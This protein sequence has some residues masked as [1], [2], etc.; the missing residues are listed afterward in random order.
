MTMIKTRQ[1]LLDQCTF[2]LA[3][4]A[5]I[6]PLFGIAIASTFLGLAILSFVIELV[7]TRSLEIFLP[8]IKAPLLLFMGTTLAALIFSP[9]PALGWGPVKKFWLFLLIPLIAAKFSRQRLSCAYSSF[10]LAGFVAAV[11]SLTQVGRLAHLAIGARITGFMGHWMT[12]SGE[13]LLVFTAL[14]AYLLFARPSRL[15]LWGIGIAII[16]CALALTMTRS[17]WIA[18][19]LGLLF[20]F[21]LRFFHWKMVLALGLAAGLLA[22]LM[23][24]KIQNRLK[25][26]SDPRDTSNYARLAFWKAGI[27]MVEAH[28]LAGVG[29]QRI[30]KVFYDYDL[31]PEDRNRL[32]F[33]P[34]HLH[35]NMLQLAAERGIPCALAWLWLIFRIGW[36]H[37]RGFRRSNGDDFQKGICAAGFISVA[38]LFVAG[39][40]EFNFGD[41]EVL[42]LFLFFT[43][44]P[45]ALGEA[46]RLEPIPRVG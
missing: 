31:N 13:L 20:L 17:V 39:L 23:P 33:F 44:A 34:V 2:L 40:F 1:E 30:L 32:S 35:N 24:A 6:A 18:A 43:S 27:K 8:P 10:L 12:L 38:V 5:S 42:M 25:S 28:P 11:C 22:L 4:L 36:D 45:Y 14:L 21:L 19:F 3:L 7:A 15:W 46:R 41:S 29:P 9:E 26:I 16:G 37:W